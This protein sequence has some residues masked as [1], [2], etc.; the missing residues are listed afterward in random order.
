MG[1]EP[2]IVLMGIAC[3]CAAMSGLC[4]WRLCDERMR[5]VQRR[6]ILSEGGRDA[7]A[8]P[9]REDAQGA[10]MLQAWALAWAVDASR[11][12]GSAGRRPIPR[13]SDASERLAR[14]AALAGMQDAL[15]CDGCLA[16]RSRAAGIGF[17]V[18]GAV[19]AAFSWELAALLA[20][21][22]AAYGWRLLP[23]ALRAR[24]EWRAREL[25]QR[26]PEMLDVLAMG[27]R[28]G[29]SFDGALALYEDHFDTALACAFRSA[30]QQWSCG[31]M[32]RE[33]A[34][35]SIAATYDSFL[36]R[37]AIDNVVRSLRFGTSLTCGLEDVAREA[38]ADYKAHR[39]ERV[40]KVPI[41]MM[42]PTAAL[43]LPA[44]LILVLGPVLLQL[45]GNI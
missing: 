28:S 43:M 10:S 13:A 8:I 21:A 45:A 19:G 3:A 34:L 4:A 33:D 16:V 9:R 39:Q 2:K 6:R 41:K 5:R 18:A 22:G 38:R 11:R 29:L 1:M 35:R 36:F 32:R 12:R 15:S 40:A 14:A 24:A 25:E 27:M 30:Q 42:L 23:T 17:A 26:L 44:M 7:K 31:L 20:L 37:R